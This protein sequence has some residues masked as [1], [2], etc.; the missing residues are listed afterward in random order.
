MRVPL[1]VNDF[2]YRAE[3]VSADAI[4]VVDEPVQPAAPVRPRPTPTC[5]LASE[6][7]RP[8]WT[9]SASASVSG[10]P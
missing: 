4:A 10:L 6:P 8:G 2:L 1:T 3:V 9:R 5:S 7:G